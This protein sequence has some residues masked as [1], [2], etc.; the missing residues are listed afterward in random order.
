MNSKV[1]FSCFYYSKLLLAANCNE[2]EYRPV[3]LFIVFLCCG[4]K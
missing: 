3:D 1:I 2:K 4:I